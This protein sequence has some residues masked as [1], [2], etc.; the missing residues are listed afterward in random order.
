LLHV[1]SGD[2]SQEY[3]CEINPF[4]KLHSISIP[5]SHLGD[6]WETDGRII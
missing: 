4:R 5:L 3:L 1:V 2:P 6:P